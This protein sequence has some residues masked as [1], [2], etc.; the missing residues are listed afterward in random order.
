[1]LNN[2]PAELSRTRTNY[3]RGKKRLRRGEGKA[4]SVLNKKSWEARGRG[5]SLKLGFRGGKISE[6]K[7]RK[8]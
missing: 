6:I 1:L 5:A 2:S 3:K 7:G 8:G 4:K